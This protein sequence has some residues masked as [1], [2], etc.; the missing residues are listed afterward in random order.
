MTVQTIAEVTEQVWAQ[1]TEAGTIVHTEAVSYER[2]HL[3]AS[4]L[5]EHLQHKYLLLNR[6]HLPAGS[7]FRDL[8][9]WKPFPADA[10]LRE[11]ACAL[12]LR[13][14]S[15]PLTFDGRPLVD[16]TDVADAVN[17]QVRRQWAAENAPITKVKVHGQIVTA[18][19]QR[20]F[21]RLL[22]DTVQW[23]VE[24]D[25]ALASEPTTRQELESFLAAE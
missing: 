17:E 25:D 5:N 10:C 13:C 22:K 24:L 9:A 14:V 18:L 23:V 2:A 4:V 11:E 8:P 3:T 16:R 20:I 19:E 6:V 7:F 1:L 21:Q 15:K 12:V